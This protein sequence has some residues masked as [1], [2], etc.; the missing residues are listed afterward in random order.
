MNN[1]IHSEK[2]KQ[3]AKGHS[4]AYVRANNISGHGALNEE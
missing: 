2:I 1:C 3:L 4:T